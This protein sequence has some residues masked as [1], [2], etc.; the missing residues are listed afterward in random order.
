MDPLRQFFDERCDF[1]PTACSTSAAL[2]SAYE[3]WAREA[4]ERHLLEGRQFAERL[5]DRGCSKTRLHGGVRAW[6]GIALV[7]YQTTPEKADEASG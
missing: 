1:Y 6:Q 7:S 3:A 4:G 2:R 5:L